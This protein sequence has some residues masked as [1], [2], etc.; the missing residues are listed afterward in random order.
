MHQAL[1]LDSTQACISDPEKD[2]KEK[3]AS[4]HQ[5][6]GGEKK[7]ILLAQRPWEDMFHHSAELQNQIKQ[8]IRRGLM[9]KAEKDKNDLFWKQFL[10]KGKQE[11][12]NSHILELIKSEY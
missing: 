2:L 1:K 4:H 5:S 12:L 11:R 3:I 10:K 6:L 8:W 7:I 9:W